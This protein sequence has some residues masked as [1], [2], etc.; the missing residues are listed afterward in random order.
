[1]LEL[2]SDKLDCLCAFIVNEDN[3]RSW[4][5][6]EQSEEVTARA[7]SLRDTAAQAAGLAEKLRALRA[8]AGITDRNLY[9]SMLSG[10]IDEE[11]RYIRAVRP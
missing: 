9:L 10:T 2:I 1:M 11:C 3:K 4:E 7:A 8:C 6:W 5:Q